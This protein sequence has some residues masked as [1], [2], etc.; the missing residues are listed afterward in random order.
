MD[1]DEDEDLSCLEDRY[2]E[3]QGRWQTQNGQQ[4]N[5]FCGRY[6]TCLGLRWLSQLFLP[7]LRLN[8]ARAPHYSLY[9]L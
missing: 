8:E 5:E 3:N 9:Q 1:E 2:Q 7:A 6:S 4:G